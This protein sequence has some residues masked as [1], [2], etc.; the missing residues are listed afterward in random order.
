MCACACVCILE[1]SDP[2]DSS[3]NQ[4]AQ[5][6]TNW[7]LVSGQASPIG[8]LLDVLVDDVL[9]LP[10]VPCNEQRSRPSW[11]APHHKVSRYQGVWS[12]SLIPSFL[13]L[14]LLVP[15]Q[16]SRGW[17][18]ASAWQVPAT[19]FQA[20]RTSSFRFPADLSVEP[21]NP[22]TQPVSNMMKPPA[23]SAI[24]GTRSGYLPQTSCVKH[25]TEWSQRVSVETRSILL[26]ITEIYQIINLR[27]V[28]QLF[29]IFVHSYPA[30]THIYP[31]SSTGPP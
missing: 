5:R 19:W 27:T 26:T 29:Y 8:C 23:F 21:G 14:D 28:M 20:P 10:T 17:A 22:A 9:E 12:A 2:V 3:W 1:L 16:G 11:Q 24:T 7:R 6:L 25:Y 13:F 30:V 18:D 15:M 31:Y 4:S